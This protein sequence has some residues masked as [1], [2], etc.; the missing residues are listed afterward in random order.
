MT[1][2]SDR[3]FER[4]LVL[5]CQTGDEAAFAELVERYRHRLHYFVRKLL[6]E[7]DA[8]DVLQD[9]WLDVYRGLSRLSD[10][11]ALAAWLYRI[12][13][14]RAYRVLR[15]RRSGQVPLDAA[16]L[17]DESAEATFSAD[18]AARIHVALGELEPQHREVLILRFLE[19]MSYEDIAR[20]VGCPLGT[21]RSRLHYSKLALRRQLERKDPHE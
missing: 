20:I 15:K 14:D 7:A 10:A 5:R 9:V 13:R 6:G 17:I 8:D 2:P 3:L 16:E 21:V 1:D 4:L 19:E 11:A 18:E 12:A